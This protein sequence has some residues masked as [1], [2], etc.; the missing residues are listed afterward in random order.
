MAEDQAIREFERFLAERADSLMR[1]AFLLTGRR[2]AAQD[3]LQTALP[4]V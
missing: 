4:R 1:T 2:E 3:L